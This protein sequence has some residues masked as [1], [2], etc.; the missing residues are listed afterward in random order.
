MAQVLW[1]GTPAYGLHRVQAERRSV[2]AAEAQPHEL[3][4]R[5][6]TE[7]LLAPT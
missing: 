6:V 5:P 3:S 2:L 4:P 7:P 1:D